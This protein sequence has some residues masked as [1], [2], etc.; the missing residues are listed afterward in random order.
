MLAGGGERAEGRDEL[1]PVGVGGQAVDLAD[2][3]ADAVALAEDR[4]VFEAFDEF[5]AEGPFGHEADRDEAVLGACDRVLEV[6]EDA[7]GFHHASR[8]DDDPVAR[9]VQGHALLDVLDEAH[10]FEE[11]RVAALVEDRTRLVVELFAVG[12]DDLGGLRAQR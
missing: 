11:E 10:A 3:T 8:G 4:N 6:V 1:A 2:P 7:P 9:A 12:R 5:A